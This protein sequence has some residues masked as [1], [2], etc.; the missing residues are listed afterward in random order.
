MPLSLD[1]AMYNDLMI[2]NIYVRHVDFN[3]KGCH[4]R[5]LTEAIYYIDSMYK[6]TRQSKHTCITVQLVYYMVHQIM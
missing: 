3:I 1:E 6:L 5:Y 2:L 4:C